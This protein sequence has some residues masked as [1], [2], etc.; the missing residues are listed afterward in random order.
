MDRFPQIIFLSHLHD[1]NIL[2]L[3]L[4]S[5]DEIIQD[6]QEKVIVL[7]NNLGY[8]YPQSIDVKRMFIF[9]LLVILLSSKK[10]LWDYGILGFWDYGIMGLW[11]IG[12]MGY[13]DYG[14]MGLWDYGIMG[15]LDSGI[16]GFWDSGILGLWDIGIMGYRDYGI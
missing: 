6:F 7:G 2:P 11:D 9:A 1:G 3:P 8:K 4:S 13:R 15:L 5:L 16:L 14:I 12:I 10:G